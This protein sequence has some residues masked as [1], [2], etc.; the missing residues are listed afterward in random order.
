MGHNVKKNTIELKTAH[1]KIL[2]FRG[3]TTKR[4]RVNEQ[5][6]DTGV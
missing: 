2:F 5:E 4:G 1:G 6:S 3:K